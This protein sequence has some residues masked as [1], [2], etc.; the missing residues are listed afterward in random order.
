M[1]IQDNRKV[2][3]AVVSVISNITI[4]AAKIAAAIFSGSVSVLSEALHSFGDVVASL[5]AFFTVR[6]SDKPADREH[7]Y[8]HGK[9]EPFAGLIEALLL[10]IAGIYVGYEAFL[11]LFHPRP[12]EVDI[13]FVIIM[14]SA[15]LNIFISTYIGKVARETDSDA[16]RA[17]AM[18]LKADVITSAGVLLALFFVRWTKNL[19]FDPIIALILTLWILFSAGKIAFQS[20]QLLMDV[21]LSD[22]ELATIE[23]ILK[24]HPGIYDF[25]QLRTRKSG[26]YRHVDAHILVNDNLSLIQAHELTEEV[27]D[28]IRQSLPNVL[29]SLHV[30]PYHREREHRANFHKDINEE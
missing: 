20:F 15:I 8:G 16:L 26:S 4:T 1:H 25:H 19:V 11:R 6:V 21:K 12:I 2:I 10:M 5:I 13:A 27:E 28:R 14:A 24:T 3:A 17:D 30:E 23:N 29:I 18:H 22:E 7:P 9:F